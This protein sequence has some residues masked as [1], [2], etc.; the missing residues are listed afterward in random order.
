M[1]S[2][3]SRKIRFCDVAQSCG[4]DIEGTRPRTGKF[5][6]DAQ[7]ARIRALEA[8][9]KDLLSQ[10]FVNWTNDLQEDMI[11]S[12]L[13]IMTD[14]E[15]HFDKS[16]D[17]KRKAII[18]K[19]VARMHEDDGDLLSI[20]DL[21]AEIGTS[22][23]TLDRAFRE[24]FGIGPKAYY[25][26]IRLNRVRNELTRNADVTNVAE[27]ANQFD[28]WHMG[29][30]A[31]DYR[32]L[33]GELPSR[34]F[35]AHAKHVTRALDRPARLARLCDYCLAEPAPAF[36]GFLG[37]MVL[38]PNPQWSL[39]R[40]GAFGLRARSQTIAIRIAVLSSAL[41]SDAHGLAQSMGDIIYADVAISSRVD[42]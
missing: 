26:R 42:R 7:R 17:H 19:A 29:Q 10:P 36:F 37:P 5:L 18:D 35:P 34:N 12:V 27:A 9:V 6:A 39:W 31:K 23:R 28:F 20:A 13:A 2:C 4:F 21:C 22:W 16:S 14:D 41:H 8:R 11:L 30:F 3:L 1:L 24:K 38:R 32:T 15:I 40:S 25:T 33:F